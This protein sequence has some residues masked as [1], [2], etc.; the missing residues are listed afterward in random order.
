VNSKTRHSTFARSGVLR[1]VFSVIIIWFWRWI[2]CKCLSWHCDVIRGLLL[3]GLSFIL[4]V[5][6]RRIIN[7]EMVILDTLKWSPTASWVIPTWTILTARSRSLCCSCENSN[8]FQ[9][10]KLFTFVDSTINDDHRWSKC[11]IRS[12]QTGS[13][14]GKLTFRNFSITEQDVIVCFVRI[15]GFHANIDVNDNKQLF[16]FYHK[17]IFKKN[18]CIVS[19]VD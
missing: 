14:D 1:E 8:Y 19:F 5:C 2:R 6:Q 17:N 12:L 13:W 15:N 16:W 10:G 7:L 3:W 18:L 9:N 11:L 4:P